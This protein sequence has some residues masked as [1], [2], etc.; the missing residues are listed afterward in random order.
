MLTYDD[1]V[2]DDNM[3]EV[4]AILSETQW[5]VKHL[6]QDFALLWPEGGPYTC[7]N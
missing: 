1:L 3:E 5:S 6:K 2:T 4:L 7:S